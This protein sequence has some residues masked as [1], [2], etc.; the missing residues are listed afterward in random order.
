MLATKEAVAESTSLAW[1]GGMRVC[2]DHDHGIKSKIPDRLK[3]HSYAED[4][5]QLEAFQLY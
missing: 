2:I 1:I 4:I 5:V 3:S